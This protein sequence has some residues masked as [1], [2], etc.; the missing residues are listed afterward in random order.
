LPDFFLTHCNKTGE[1]KSRRNEGIGPQN[2]KLL[3]KAVKMTVV[4]VTIT[5]FGEFRQFSATKLA[6]FF[7]TNVWSN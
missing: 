6:F 2:M 7:E 1:N 5:L 4:N 3:S